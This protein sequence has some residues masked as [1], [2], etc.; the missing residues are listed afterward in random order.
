MIVA[1]PVAR[2]PPQ[3]LGAARH[4]GERARTLL[5]LDPASS[6]YHVARL[7]RDRLHP[8]PR[9][10]LPGRDGRTTELA[11]VDTLPRRREHEGRID[12]LSEVRDVSRN[13]LHD[14]VFHGCVSLRIRLYYPYGRL[15][16]KVQGQG[17][18]RRHLRR[19]FPV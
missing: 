9:H 4:K 16:G 8:L 3:E 12:L 5:V 1:L 7:Y 2:L 18:R 15:F 10:S 17:V 6:E 11:E 13:N 14:S 19:L